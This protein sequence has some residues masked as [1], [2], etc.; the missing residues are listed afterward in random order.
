MKEYGA[1]LACPNDLFAGFTR[2]RIGLLTGE[3]AKPRLLSARRITADVTGAI[4]EPDITYA[5]QDI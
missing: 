3:R 1:R 5:E 2:W 4:T